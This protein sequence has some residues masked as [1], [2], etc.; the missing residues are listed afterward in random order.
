MGRS[1]PF[2]PSQRSELR[3]VYYRPAVDKRELRD[4]L[5]AMAAKYGASERLILQAIVYEVDMPKN[6]NPLR[7]PG[8]PG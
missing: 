6:W 7:Y 1:S 5:S 4:R 2:T 3:R 8:G